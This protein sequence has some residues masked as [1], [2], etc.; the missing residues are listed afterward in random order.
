MTALPT[1]TPCWPVPGLP[2]APAVRGDIDVDVAVVGAGLAGC[3]V[4]LRLLE[5]RPSLRIALLEADRPAAGASGRGTGLVGPRIGPPIDVAVRRFGAAAARTNYLASVDGVAAVVDLAQRYAPGSV[6][7]A[8]GQ[9]IVGRT[10]GEVKKLDRR[11]E[12]YAALGLD[13]WLAADER[14]FGGLALRY[15]TAAG[16]NPAALVAGLV[17][18]ISRRGVARYDGSP[19]RRIDGG[20]RTTCHLDH[21]RV[22]ADT[23]VVAADGG[24]RQLALPVGRLRDVH[25]CAV[26]TGPL[27]GDLLDELGGPNGDQVICAGELAPYW[28]ITDEGALVLGGGRPIDPRGM[29]P[30]RRLRALFRTWRQLEATLAAVHPRL[31]TVGLAARWS[32][33]V[34]VTEDGLPVV[35]RVQVPGRVWFAGGWCGHGLA[36]SVAASTVVADGVLGVGTTEQAVLPWARS[37]T[38]AGPLTLMPAPLLRLALT[39]VAAQQDRLTARSSRPNRHPAI[40]LPDTTELQRSTRTETGNS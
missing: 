7:R 37:H 33:V 27:P 8:A 3:A 29:S 21:G 12:T 39:A 34:T 14:A 15:P 19:V 30:A 6:R 20:S 10:A 17:A 26:A 32:G 13:A 31:A 16:A 28:R 9:L 35:G 38:P 25:T 4:A 36:A 40:A 23:V 2:P 22:R 1:G 5:R 11:A 18:E 24:A